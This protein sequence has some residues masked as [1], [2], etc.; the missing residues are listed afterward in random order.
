ML[1][2]FLAL[3]VLASYYA[4]AYDL[5]TVASDGASQRPEWFRVILSI[6]LLL[7]ALCV[8]IL[9]IDF[10]INHFKDKRIKGETDRIRD[11]IREEI[12]ESL[13]Y[14]DIYTAI[15]ENTK[16]EIEN[17]L[18]YGDM[19]QAINERIY[20][21]WFNGD[22]YEA[23]EENIKMETDR[24]KD[25]IENS[26]N[27]GHGGI[28]EAIKQIIRDD[29]YES[30]AYGII[31]ETA[32]DISKE[33]IDNSCDFGRIEKTISRHVK[34]NS[35]KCLSLCQSCANFKVASC[36]SG[37]LDFEGLQKA[38]RLYFDQQEVK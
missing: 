30:C 4:Q 3:P 25:E 36:G 2:K 15:R 7:C 33:E 24:I 22:I 23:V 10:T 34:N 9:L 29:I 35:S 17:S 5:V 31:K 32:E 37:K 28:Y 12:K 1:S 19:H 26:L 21:S 18:D 16:D 14:G 27:D 20:E 6:V 38:I 13:D 8:L 11:E